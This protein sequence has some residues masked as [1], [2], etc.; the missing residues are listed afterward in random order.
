MVSVHTVKSQ[1]K[2]LRASRSAVDVIPM[3]SYGP[4][5]SQVFRQVA[6]DTCAI[7]TMFACEGL[8]TSVQS[9]VCRQAALLIGAKVAMLTCKGLLS[10]VQSQVRRQAVLVTGAIITMLAC[11]WLLPSVQS[12][13]SRQVAPFAGFISTLLT[14]VPWHH[15]AVQHRTFKT[16]PSPPHE[17]Y[18]K[19]WIDYDTQ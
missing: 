6:L 9:Q 13:V 7:A 2:V 14:S 4:M 11:E 12:Q 5:H 8:L 10:S 15:V 18:G 3:A 1:R 17:N 19:V 16:T